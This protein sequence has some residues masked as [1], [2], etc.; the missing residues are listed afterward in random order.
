[1][2]EGGEGEGQKLQRIIKRLRHGGRKELTPAQKLAK[3][4]K[5]DFDRLGNGVTAEAFAKDFMWGKYRPIF[6]KGV[7][8]FLDHCEEARID[9]EL[10]SDF[11]EKVMAGLNFAL[12][13]GSAK[14]IDP[15]DLFHAHLC[16]EPESRFFN[17][18]LNKETLKDL[19]SSDE[20]RLIYH[21]Q[22]FWLS[23]EKN[24]KSEQLSR[25]Q[26]ETVNLWLQ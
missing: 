15:L 7:D 24:L 22:E 5:R 21:T 25:L 26:E 13:S 11:L 3:E 4:A 6:K 12:T 8:K 1:M 14:S 18:P 19:I 17:A 9:I 10:P 23:E 20:W 2:A 16:C